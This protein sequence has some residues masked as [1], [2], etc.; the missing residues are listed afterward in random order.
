MADYTR[1]ELEQML[2]DKREEERAAE[3]AAFTSS[4]EYKFEQDMRTTI[5]SSDYEMVVH[6]TTGNFQTCIARVHK[7][8]TQNKQF[9]E[10]PHYWNET[11]DGVLIARARVSAS[12]SSG[13]YGESYTTP[14]LQ[15]LGTREKDLTIMQG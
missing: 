3:E 1:E 10:R 5:K 15:I 9:I 8:E 11:R 6:K 14:T 12:Y 13:S 2:L 7:S 4:V